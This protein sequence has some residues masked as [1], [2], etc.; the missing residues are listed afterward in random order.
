MFYT[1]P[2]RV[3]QILLNLYM[4]SLAAMD[5]GGTLTVTVMDV[6]PGQDLEI[7][8]MDD[9]C[10]MDE[11]ILSEIFDPYF[12]T[13]PDGTGLG[14]SIV[15]RLVESLGGEIRVKSAKGKG[16]TVSIYLK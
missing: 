1:D 2:D 5:D 9:G 8:V 11:Q 16:T 15:H 6:Q 13:R 14:L 12:T 10:G 3:N 4:N 7:R